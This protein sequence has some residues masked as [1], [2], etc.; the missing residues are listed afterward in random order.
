MKFFKLIQ[1]N[2]NEWAWTCSNTVLA[3]IHS[4]ED[5]MWRVCW[6]REGGTTRML[7]DEFECAQDACLAAEKRWPCDGEWCESKAGGYFCNFGNS[8]FHVRQAQTCRWYALRSDGKVLGQ[9]GKVLWFANAAEACRAV[10]AER[11]TP[12]VLDPFRTPG[13]VW[14]WLKHVA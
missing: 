4:T 10:L 6:P 12:V 7:K 13:E 1:K 5:G 14:C 3:R 11:H 2:A 8:T 9:N